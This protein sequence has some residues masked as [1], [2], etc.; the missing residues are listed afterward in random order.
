MSISK[1]Y[2]Q[3]KH[4]N[5]WWIAFT[6]K[7]EAD[8]DG[9]VVHLHLTDPGDWDDLARAVLGIGSLLPTPLALPLGVAA[10]I[11]ELST[12]ADGTYDFFHLNGKVEAWLVDQP[13]VFSGFVSDESWK[14]PVGMSAAGN[15]LTGLVLSWLQIKSLANHFRDEPVPREPAE[16]PRVSHAGVAQYGSGRLLLFREP[17]ART[18]LVLTSAQAAGK[19]IASVAVNVS[20]QGFRLLLRD[21]Q[22]RNVP[23][24]WVQW[25]AF[26]PNH[27]AG[28]FGDVTAVDGRME[29]TFP[30]LPQVPVVVVNAYDMEPGPLNILRWPQP[31][32][33]APVNIARD[34]FA[35]HLTNPLTDRPVQK[36]VVAWAAVVP[37][38]ATNHFF[39]ENRRSANDE[40]ITFAPALANVPAYLLSSRPGVMAAALNNR[41]DGF[42]VSMRDFA[43][44]PAVGKTDLHY[45]A[46]VA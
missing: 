20:P 11:W 16:L 8:Y 21:D 4:K 42:L 13:V 33:A 22:G 7:D 32:I 39:G 12:N 25:V 37:N 19:A 34:R 28:S 1:V 43:G 46:Y 10:A 14:P 23:E 17:F 5:S 44:Q 27:A 30:A 40:T 9:L 45:L 15:P 18:P 6:A 41:K 36:A 2:G 26:Q 31:L 29:I 3:G 38:V 24:A 35:V